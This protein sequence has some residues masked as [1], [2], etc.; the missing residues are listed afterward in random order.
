MYMTNSLKKTHL[1]IC[2][3]MSAILSDFNMAKIQWHSIRMFS[4]GSHWKY[5][6]NIQHWFRWQISYHMGTYQ[7]ITWRQSFTMLYGMTRAEGV[8]RPTCCMDRRAFG[9]VIVNHYCGF[10]YNETMTTLRVSSAGSQ[11][12]RS[13]TWWNNTQMSTTVN[14]T[15]GHVT[16]VFITGTTI[17]VPYLYVQQIPHMDSLHVWATRNL[18]WA[19]S[20]NVSM[21][22]EE[23][24]IQTCIRNMF[25]WY[26]WLLPLS[27]VISR[28]IT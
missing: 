1:K 11:M 22:F 7:C 16:L 4:W 9:Q 26:T 14:H 20:G 17:L 15:I 5:I 12:Q 27:S 28:F 19:I 8:T 2:L 3:R 6:I 23:F 21:N 18:L 24:S 13:T 10:L 25:T